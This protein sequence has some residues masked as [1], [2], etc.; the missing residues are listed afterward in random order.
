MTLNAAIRSLPK[1]A[2]G[3]AERAHSV[4]VLRDAVMQELEMHREGNNPLTSNQVAALK[5]WLEATK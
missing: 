2:R 3:L 1:W 5:S 4:G